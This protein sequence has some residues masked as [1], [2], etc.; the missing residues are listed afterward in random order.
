[1][2]DL[3]V[4]IVVLGQFLP[5]QLVLDSKPGVPVLDLVLHVVV[6]FHQ[7][8]DLEHMLLQLFQ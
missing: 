1:M 8:E 5:A 2:L 4:E 6:V 7:L 3:V